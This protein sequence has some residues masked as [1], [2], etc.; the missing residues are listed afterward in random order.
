MASV[1]HW[2]AEAIWEAIS[3]S[4]PDFSVEIV[5][6]LDSTNSELMR[7]ARVGRTEPILLITERQTAGR[8][9]LGREWISEQSA[10]SLTFSLGLPIAP[11][12][13]S[14]L[15]LAVGLSIVE[16]LHP[17]LQLKWPNDVWFQQRKVAGILMETVAMNAAM[18]STMKYLVIG[19]GIN[20]VPRSNE[21]LRTPSAGLSEVLPNVDAPKALLCIVP[22]LVEMVQQFVPQGFAP[23]QSAYHARDCLWNESVV[24]SDGTEGIA[25]G[26]DA[27]GVLWIRTSVGLKPIHSAEVSV[28]PLR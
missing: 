24:C 3:P 12:N 5:P 11:A 13:W 4:I 26:V 2:Q 8:G 19:V 27:D 9:R 6:E 21:G 17:A 1:I 15:S 7:R 22:P 25:Q 10:T 18:S 14:G 20:L 23:W 16:S 28:K